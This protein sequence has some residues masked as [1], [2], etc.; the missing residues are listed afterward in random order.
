MFSMEKQVKCMYVFYFD[1]YFCFIRSFF[2]VIDLVV[3]RTYFTRKSL[4]VYNSSIE[5]PYQSCTFL[6]E[7][8]NFKCT[9]SIQRI[10]KVIG[11]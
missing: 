11:R 7:N 2:N 6:N 10:R 3:V 8:V 9:M 5:R 1:T 4:S